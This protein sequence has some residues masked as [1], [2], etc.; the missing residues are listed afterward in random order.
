MAGTQQQY[1]LLPRPVTRVARTPTAAGWG[2][3]LPHCRLSRPRHS[4]LQIRV[5][6]YFACGICVQETI[7]LGQLCQKS[8]DDVFVDS[9]KLCFIPLH[10]VSVF[11]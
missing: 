2:V 8:V 5:L 3:G 4:P 11:P 10:G 9:W 7:S 1:L 6:V